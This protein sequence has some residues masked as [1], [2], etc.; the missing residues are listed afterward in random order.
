MPAED[1][2]VRAEGANRKM[3]EKNQI[4]WQ[5]DGSGNLQT[6]PLQGKGTTHEAAFT[7]PNL[8]R[9]EIYALYAYCV[10]L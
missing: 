4:I 6:S 5:G 3:E 9:E 8:V 1:P 2:S 10:A 7:S